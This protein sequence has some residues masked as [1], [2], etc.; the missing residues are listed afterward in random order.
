MGKE[1]KSTRVMYSSFFYFINTLILVVNS[2]GDTNT[3]KQ[4]NIS[5][6]QMDIF[7]D[8]HFQYN[9]TMN[10]KDEILLQKILEEL[11]TLNQSIDLIV[12]KQ[13]FNIKENRKAVKTSLN[14]SKQAKR[15]ALDP[16][17]M[18][19]SILDQSL[20]DIVA[21]KKGK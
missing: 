6:F 5:S 19:K 8:V 20:D 17:S 4:T 21:N 3:I 1:K 11:R 7:A 14:E 10:N 13:L 16:R 12:K 18:I 2:I 15:Q 9:I